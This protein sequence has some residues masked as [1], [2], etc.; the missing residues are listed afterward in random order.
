MRGF[1]HTLIRVGPLCDAYCT[2]TLTCEA[3]ITRDTRG[4]PVLT[5]WREASGPQLWRITLQPGEAN[6]PKNALYHKYGYIKSV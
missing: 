6:L 1:R 4:T 2:F 3:V 5:V